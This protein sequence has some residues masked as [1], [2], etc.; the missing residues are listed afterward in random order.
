MS[1]QRILG[2]QSY[3]G[4]SLSA[5][6]SLVVVHVFFRLFEPLLQDGSQLACVLVAQLEVLK[7]TNGRLTEHRTMHSRQ[8][9]SLKRIELPLLIVAFPMGRIF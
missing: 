3:G 2:S 6:V 4:S 5:S 1:L 7:A 9:V 8:G